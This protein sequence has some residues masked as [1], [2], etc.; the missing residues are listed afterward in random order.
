MSHKDLPTVIAIYRVKSD[1]QAEF[2]ELLREHHPVLVRLGLATD[3]VPIVYKGFEQDGGP[4]VFEIFRWKNAEAPGL[5]HQAPEVARVWEAMGT[6]TE[7]RGGRPQFEF[8]HVERL[9]AARADA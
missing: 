1:R 2:L 8:P 7:E 4:I 3:E 5:A 6:L 9:G